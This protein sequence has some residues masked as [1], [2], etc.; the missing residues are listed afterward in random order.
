MAPAPLVELTHA[1]PRAPQTEAIC[2]TFGIGTPPLLAAEKAFSTGSA[3]VGR[4][5]LLAG[6]RPSAAASLAW[7]GRAGHE[8]RHEGV[9]A[10]LHT[11]RSGV[12]GDHDALRTEE[13]HGLMARDDRRHRG[14]AVLERQGLD[15]ARAPT[16][17]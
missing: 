11:V 7:Y 16:G 9:G 5:D 17:R 15:G 14:D 2:G 6:V 12:L 8:L 10:D 4:D 3:R 13:R 1:P